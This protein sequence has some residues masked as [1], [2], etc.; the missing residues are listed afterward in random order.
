MS[1][2]FVRPFV[3]C[4][5][6]SLGA[7]AEI[8]ERFNMKAEVSGIGDAMEHCQAFMEH[9]LTE[10]VQVF[11]D[12]KSTRETVEHYDVYFHLYDEKQE[13]WAQ[14]RVN[15]RGEITYHSIRDFRIKGRSFQ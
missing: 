12:E 9:L 13:G 5:L 8:F 7:C 10:D 15:M 4:T 1:Q 3:L 11:V 6:L 14:C 2:T